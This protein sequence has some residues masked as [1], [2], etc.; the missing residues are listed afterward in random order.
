MPKT[1]LKTK[2][3]NK[4]NYRSLIHIRQP[5][6]KFDIV[7]KCECNNKSTTKKAM[8]LFCLEI[9]KIIFSFY[10]NG[11]NVSCFVRFPV[12]NRIFPF[13]LTGVLAY[14]P[15]IPKLLRAM[16]TQ[17]KKYGISNNFNNTVIQSRCFQ[18]FCLLFISEDFC[19]FSDDSQL[20]CNKCQ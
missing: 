4:K 8:G 18:C 3:L 16:K 12:N 19:G 7:T 13:P 20:L 14:D 1:S 15:N 6:S 2:L 5:P 10:L 11:H 17:V 9:E